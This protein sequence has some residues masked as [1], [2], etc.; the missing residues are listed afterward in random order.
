M[1]LL[2]ILEKEIA[3]NFVLGVALGVPIFTKLFHL[4]DATIMVISFLDKVIS[5]IVMAL[6]VTGSMFY[7]GKSK[8]V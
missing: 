4:H 3:E 5:N 1:R 7:A 8:T 2:T 6:V